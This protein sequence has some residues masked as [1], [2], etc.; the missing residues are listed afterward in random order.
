MRIT[1]IVATDLDGGIGLDG[2]LPW[3]LPADLAHFKRLTLGHPVVMGRKTHRSIGRPLP[4]RTNIVLTRDPSYEAPDCVVV[5]S[6]D[7]AIRAAR[8]VSDHECFV[9]GGAEIYGLFLPRAD[10][11]MRT[12]VHDR[13][14]CDTF[15]PAIDESGWT[16]TSRLERPA[17]AKNPV[18]CSF[19]VLD[20][21]PDTT[22]LDPEID[23]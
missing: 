8:R 14:A 13:Y 19:V 6:T 2:R 3:H 20:R 17:D 5:H 1:L 18:D 21:R 23:R 7:E 9:I 11:L 10:R 15:F 16:E 4:E 22:T 12:I